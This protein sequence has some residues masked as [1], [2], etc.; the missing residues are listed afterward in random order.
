[1]ALLKPQLDVLAEVVRNKDR[2]LRM[3]SL[4]YPDLLV[5]KAVV[6]DLFGS[7]IASQLL[8]RDDSAEILAWHGFSEMIPA[9]I[10]SDH[11][12]FADRCK[13]RVHRYC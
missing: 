2:G 1:M 5:G 11:I 13:L 6:E 12:F 7:E 8:Y 3:L 9:V 4:G 10:D